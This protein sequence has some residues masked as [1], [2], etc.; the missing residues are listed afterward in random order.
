MVLREEQIHRYSR[1]ILLPDVGGRGQRKL[2][3]GELQMCGLGSVGVFCALYLAAAGVGKLWLSDD[4]MVS[5]G[6]VGLAGIYQPEDVG[7][8]REEIVQRRLTS[9][10]SDAVCLVGASPSARAIYCGDAAAPLAHQEGLRVGVR[11]HHAIVQSGCL[12]CAAVLSDGEGP[13]D[14]AL[15]MIAGSLGAYEAL[16]ALLGNVSLVSDTKLSFEGENMQYQRYTVFCA[17]PS[18][19]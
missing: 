16:Y 5:V 2:L 7:F 19:R 14:E 10:N 13:L 3:A 6:D 15:A 4:T 17:Q 18:K 9:L 11:N 8:S 1:Q 12:A